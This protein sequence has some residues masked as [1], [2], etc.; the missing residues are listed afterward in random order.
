[1]GR[2]GFIANATPWPSRVTYG[3]MR[4]MILIGLMLGFVLGI[5]LTLFVVILLYG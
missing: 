3:T 5:F 2:L 1:M 4:Q